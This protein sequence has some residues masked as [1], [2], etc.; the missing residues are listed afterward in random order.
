MSAIDETEQTRESEAVARTP[1]PRTARRFRDLEPASVFTHG[2]GRFPSVSV[3]VPTYNEAENLPHVLPSVPDEVSEVLVVDGRSSDNT[4]GVLQDV[5]P[6]ARVVLQDGRGKGN[7]IGCGLREATGDIVVMLDADGS[8]DPTEIPRFVSALLAGADFAKGTRYHPGGGSSD[9]SL[10]RSLGNRALA[11]VF[12]VLYG[13]RHSDLCYG[14]NAFWRHLVPAIHRDCAG[15]EIE[16]VLK[17]RAARK[18]LHVV[19]VPSFEHSRIHGASNLNAITDGFR[20]LWTI[21]RERLTPRK[22][23]PDP[24]PP[25]RSRYVARDVSQDIFETLLA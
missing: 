18:E 11:T 4:L 20:V 7:A 5:C 3:I 19:E 13:T 8:A 10:F 9:L 25:P 16:A 14:Y 21:I 2:Q 22:R 23:L 6:K 24:A 1:F 15:F 17:A 12:N